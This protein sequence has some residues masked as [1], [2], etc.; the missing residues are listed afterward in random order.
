MPVGAMKVQ[1]Q[2]MKRKMSKNFDTNPSNYD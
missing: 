1:Y 2:N